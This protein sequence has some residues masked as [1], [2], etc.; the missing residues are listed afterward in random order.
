VRQS[1]SLIVVNQYIHIRLLKHSERNLTY[2]EEGILLK[3]SNRAP[4]I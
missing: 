2:Y 3:P 4:Y 1:H